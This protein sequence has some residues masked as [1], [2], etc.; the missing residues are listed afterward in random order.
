MKKLLILVMVLGV[1]SMANA[2][3]QIS[4]AGDQNPVDSEITV[5]PSEE[6]TLDIW[7]DADIVQGVGE[8]YYFLTADPLKATVSGGVSLWAGDVIHYG[9]GAS[10]YVA[11]EGPWGGIALVNASL[12]PAG[13]TLV[14]EIL[15]HCESEED[16]VVDLYFTTDFATFN[17]V[18]SVTIH[19]MIPEPMTMALLGLGGL[20]LRRRK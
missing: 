2:T 18:D 1:A 10:A 6:T 5:L 11:G 16:A 17:L 15:F 19:Q 13:S 9:T 20:F 8:G 3:L 12:I 4:V 7:T 14:D